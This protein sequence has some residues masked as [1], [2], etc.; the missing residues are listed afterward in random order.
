MLLQPK[1]GERKNDEQIE[2]EIAANEWFTQR[3][4][5]RKP[6]RP[7]APRAM[8]SAELIPTY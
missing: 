8:S 2:E 3:G 4:L 6:S 5:I 1:L 7:R